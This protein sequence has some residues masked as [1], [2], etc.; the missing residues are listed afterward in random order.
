MI[1]E[2]YRDYLIDKLQGKVEALEEELLSYKIKDLESDLNIP[3]DKITSLIKGASETVNSS[4]CVLK[5]FRDYHEE[6]D[7]IQVM[8]DLSTEL[9]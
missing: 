5:W 6:P 2:D 7:L 1:K 8:W 3:E 4:G 9:E